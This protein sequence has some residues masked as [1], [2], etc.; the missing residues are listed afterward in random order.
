ML[1]AA[2]AK[3]LANVIDDLTFDADH[4]GG[5]LFVMD[6]PSS[7]DLAVAVFAT[8]GLAQLTR[9]A[10]DLPGLQLRFRAGQFDPRPAYTL[11]RACYSALTCLDLVTLDSDGD[12]EVFVIGCTATQSDLI[13][14]GKDEI[15]RHEFSQNYQL[16]TRALTTHRTT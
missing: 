9:A 10:T 14:M 12:D 8:P 6:L 3:Y 15:E 2:V 7:P 5:N 4:E 16:R 13:P 1:A 11:G